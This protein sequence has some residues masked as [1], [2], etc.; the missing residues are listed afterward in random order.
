MWRIL[1]TI[2]FKCFHRSKYFYTIAIRTE[3]DNLIALPTSYLCD[4]DSRRQL[5]KRITSGY[6]G[7]GITLRHATPV[8]TILQLSKHNPQIDT[9]SKTEEVGEGNRQ[10]IFY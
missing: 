6:N 4:C 1:L 9:L 8:S 3:N 5:S 10:L 2:A 7:C